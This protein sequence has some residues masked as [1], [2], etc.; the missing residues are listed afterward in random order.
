MLFRSCQKSLPACLA[1]ALSGLIALAGVPAL[2]QSAAD[3]YRGKTITVYASVASGAYDLYARVLARHMQPRI[4]GQP[5]MIVV[6][7]PGAG[8]VKAANY[9]A[10]IAPRDGT[11]L[12]VPLKPVAMTQILRDKGIK[13]DASKFNWVGSMVDAPGVLTVWHT[14]PAKT[15]ADAKK[16]E[17]VMASSGF[18]AETFI[19]PTVI[20]SV[21]GTK[22]KVVTGYKGM[23]G[24]L[25]AIERGEAHGVSTVYGS[26]KGLKPKW[27]SENK[28][29]FL[30]QISLKRTA[31][32]PD[33]PSVLEFA[34][35][36]DDREIL[37]FLTLG[38]VIGRSIVASPGI[39]VD[40][41]AALRAAFDQA[42]RAPDY[43]KETV[44]RGMLVNPTSGAEVQ[45]TVNRLI[46]TPAAIVA[47]VKVA[48]NSARM[49]KKK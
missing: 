31:D 33:V 29:R 36:N 14:A 41:L 38:N 48:L 35:N 46:A 49:Q 10:N 12:L 39:A 28:V 44:Q 26:L 17:V 25:L 27:L 1:V 21:L 8:G 23:S 32:L 47:K 45:E 30:A 43:L 40:R 15:L 4:D 24:M 3:F 18:G 19:F 20:N 2:A 42:V 37:A 34:K 5:A 6:N 11:A 16:N 7:M 22:F 13:Y 9:F